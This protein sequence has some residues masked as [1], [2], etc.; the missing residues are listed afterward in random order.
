MRIN[1]FSLYFKIF[2]GLWGTIMIFAITP[3]LMILVSNQESRDAFYEHAKK[4]LEKNI[5]IDI[6]AAANS[7]NIPSLI[8]Q[9]KRAEK[10]LNS[11]IFI[12]DKNS[13][14]L[15][16]KK[17]PLGADNIIKTM[18]EDKVVLIKKYSDDK[19]DKRLIR[20]I[21]TDEY[22]LISYPTGD[23]PASFSAIIFAKHVNAF[24]YIFF[25]SSIASLIITRYFSKPL[26]TLS[27]AVKRISE[28]DFSVRVAEELNRKDEIGQLGKDFDI[29]A[30]KLQ[31]IRNT[32]EATL[33]N[34]SHELRSPLTRLRLSLELARAKAGDNATQA[35]DRIELESDRL[36]EMIGQ[37]LEIS[38]IKSTENLEKETFGIKSAIQ[39]V[40]SDGYFEANETGKNLTYSEDA[41]YFIHGN[42]ALLISCFENIIRN[43]IKYS[44]SKVDVKVGCEDS[45]I[46][47]SISDDGTGVADEHLS[48]IFKPFY[49][50]QADRDRKTGG[51]GLG[52]AIAKTIVDAHNGYIN[53]I[54]NQYEGLTIEVRLP[55]DSV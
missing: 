20:V 12:F 47:V 39:I 14:E 10:Y 8:N 9:V 34:L 31:H 54:N 49:R 55:I 16:N 40:L 6:R 50:V 32:K 51:I 27:K 23:K 5:V 3:L 26:L 17:A 35:L 52:L 44:S 24:I 37:L 43:A 45:F 4:G 36:N 1:R 19:N 15:R 46:V 33:R 28:G 41:E 18:T 25:L 53:A 42:Q 38:R 7:G 30:A 22:V 11:E 13:K 29:M 21:K 2:V 48:E